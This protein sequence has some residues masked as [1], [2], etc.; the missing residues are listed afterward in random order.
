M[1]GNKHFTK[2]DLRFGYWQVEIK[3]KDKHKTTFSLGP[4]EFYEC[5]LLAFG[6]TNAPAMFRSLMEISMCDL[7]LR[8]CFIFLD[9]IMVFSK[10]FDDHLKRSENVFEKTGKTYLLKLKASMFELFMSEV[11]YLGHSVS[12]EG[13]KTDPDKIEALKS[14]PVSEHVKNHAFFWFHGYITDAL[15]KIMQEFFTLSLSCWQD[16]LQQKGKTQ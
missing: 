14:W 15:L 8:E 6:L 12:A 16:T 3:E 10:S 2:S 4:L 13:V 1:I 7:H 5:N 9:D 11:K